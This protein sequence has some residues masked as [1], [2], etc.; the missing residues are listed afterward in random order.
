MA[1][2]LHPR[3]ISLSFL[4]DPESSGNPVRVDNRFC[5]NT[6]HTLVSLEDST[7][8]E[9]ASKRMH[10]IDQGLRPLH[11]RTETARGSIMGLWQSLGKR[12]G[13][14]TPSGVYTRRRC[15][16]VCMYLR[17]LFVSHFP[18]LRA[19]HGMVWD[20]SSSYS[21][22]APSSQRKKERKKETDTI[23]R[24]IAARCKRYFPA[25]VNFRLPWHSRRVPSSGHDLDESKMTGPKSLFGSIGLIFSRQTLFANSVSI[26]RVIPPGVGG[27]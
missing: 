4:R 23:D 5:Q 17:Y 22:S 24:S 11:C 2:N 26:V 25:R 14:E 9:Q 3:S 21:R 19:W 12:C 7:E 8:R 10:H 13:D 20:P 15:R 1:K 27:I 16:S 18:M 6:H